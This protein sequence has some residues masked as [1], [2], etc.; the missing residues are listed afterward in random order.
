MEHL[1]E[2]S[3]ILENVLVLGIAIGST[4]KTNDQAIPFKV[5]T[6]GEMTTFHSMSLKKFS[7][8]LLHMEEHFGHFS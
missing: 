1:I 5:I 3:T 7:Q 6:T 8:I 2:M 4:F